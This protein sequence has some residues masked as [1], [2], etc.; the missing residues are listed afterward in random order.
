MRANSAVKRPST[1]YY[2]IPSSTSGP[3]HSV[4]VYLLVISWSIPPVFK[5][6]SVVLLKKSD[7]HSHLGRNTYLQR[8]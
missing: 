6:P 8:M 2:Y 5:G 3:F 1:T 4:S 7:F